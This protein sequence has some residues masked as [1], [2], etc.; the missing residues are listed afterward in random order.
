MRVEK[1]HRPLARPEQRE[2]PVH[3]RWM[4]DGHALAQ[5][6][7]D[8]PDDLE[9]EWRYFELF[10]RAALARPARELQRIDVVP[11]LDV[12]SRDVLVPRSGPTAGNGDDSCRIDTKR[13]LEPAKK[14]DPVQRFEA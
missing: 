11:R 9:I 14:G 5:H 3:Q 1:A 13:R 2:Q 6:P 4:Q 8:H 7:L 12:P 10:G